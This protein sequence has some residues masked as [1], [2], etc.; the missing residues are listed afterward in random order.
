MMAN[1]ENDGRRV[2][3]RENELH[4]NRFSMDFRVALNFEFGIY[5]YSATSAVFFPYFT[6]GHSLP[7]CTTHAP[8]DRIEFDAFRIVK[9]REWMESINDHHECQLR[10]NNRHFRNW[11]IARLITFSQPG[12]DQ[13]PTQY[14]NE[15]KLGNIKIH[16]CKSHVIPFSCRNDDIAAKI[17]NFMWLCWKI[18]GWK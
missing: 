18:I 3:K 14:E 9:W 12:S 13:C 4:H 17:A 2:T 8:L 15:T 7:H 10:A 11:F 5:F 16:L 1:S 6:L